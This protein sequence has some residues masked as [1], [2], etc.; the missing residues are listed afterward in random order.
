M[1]ETKFE[2]IV[3]NEIEKLKKGLSK[4]AFKWMWGSRKTIVLLF[5][6]SLIISMFSNLHGMNESWAWEVAKALIT[7]NGLVLGFSILGMTVFARRGFTR[8]A[9]KVTLQK[10]FAGF[11]NRLGKSGEKNKDAFNEN[12]IREFLSLFFHPF[13]ETFI[14]QYAVMLSMVYLLASVGLAFCLF[15]VNDVTIGNPIFKEL[16]SSIYT[17]AIVMLLLGVFLVLRGIFSLM[18]KNM[19]IEIKGAFK[20]VLDSLQKE[21]KRKEAKT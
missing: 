17:L 6:I 8:A 2:A 5:V 12:V 21:K 3:E 1:K 13:F 15:G 19:E 10:Q 9:F 18:E 20:T 7:I 16:F 11:I 4:E 14:V